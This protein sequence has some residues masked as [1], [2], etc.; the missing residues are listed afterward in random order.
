M[1]ST[2][3]WLP[4]PSKVSTECVADKSGWDEVPVTGPASPQ[5]GVPAPDAV[6]QLPIC[7]TDRA[8]ELWV[9]GAHG[10]AGESTLVKLDDSWL[11]GGHAWP[12]LSPNGPARLIITARTNVRGLLAAKAVAKQWATGL[13]T[14]VEVFGL[15]LVADAPSRL[16]K[17]LR[18][19]IK[20]VG[21]GYPRTW[22][23][24]W[25]EPWRL[26]EDP[27]L[28]ASPREVRRLVDDLH[29][30]LQTGAPLGATNRKDRNDGAD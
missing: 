5:R 18:D 9:V 2:N 10:G 16:P 6:D 22:H 11:A 28:A 1:N 17:P 29:N 24:P 13:V 3:P 21:G 20:I 25:I 4:L 7:R 30:L 26:G 8:A 23:V 27:S 15:V 14:N 12:D 19:L